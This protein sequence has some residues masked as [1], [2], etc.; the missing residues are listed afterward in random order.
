MSLGALLFAGCTSQAESSVEPAGE[1]TQAQ[2]AS[3]YFEEPEQIAGIPRSPDAFSSWQ[4]RENTNM[5]RAFV[6]KPTDTLSE[7]YNSETSL[8]DTIQ[9]SAVAGTVIDPPETLDWMFAK[10]RDLQDVRPADP[11]P[12][13]G[14][15]RCGR[16]DEAMTYTA[17][18]CG[19]ADNHSAGM[20]TFVSLE[21][22]DRRADFAM[23]RT[24][25]QKGSAGL[26]PR[27]V[28]LD[29]RETQHQDGQVDLITTWNAA[30]SP[31]ECLHAGPCRPFLRGHSR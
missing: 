27:H 15:A 19:W 17:T 3:T 26:L 22:K 18:L 28:R 2:A 11:R 5:L 13:G 14:T 4:A 20:V 24:Q 12:W 16:S 1:P 6:E 8:T 21:M 23:V 29:H 9:I 31:E 10:A 30:L 25:F 7:V